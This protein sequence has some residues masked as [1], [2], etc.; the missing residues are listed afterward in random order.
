MRVHA[1]EDDPDL[2]VLYE[3]WNETKESFVRDVLPKPFYKPY[4]AVLG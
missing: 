3:R 2:I 1:T 4:L